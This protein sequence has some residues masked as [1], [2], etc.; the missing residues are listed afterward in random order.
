V[1]KLA[2]LYFIFVTLYWLPAILLNWGS[3]GAYDDPAPLGY[4]LLRVAIPII[5]LVALYLQPRFNYR[6]MLYFAFFN[7]AILTSLFDISTVISL[8]IFSSTILFIE[9]INFSKINIDKL[10]FLLLPVFYCVGLFE[11]LGLLKSA[12]SYGEELRVVST[13]GGPN[14]SGVIFGCFSVYFATTLKKKFNT[15]SFINFLLCV[16]FLFLSGSLSAIISFS[17]VLAF[18]FPKII[19]FAPVVLIPILFINDFFLLKINYLVYAVSGAGETTGSFSDRLENF[20]YILATISS[21]PVNFL[22]GMDT[23]SESD[24]FGTLGRF[25]VIGL[26]LLL[27]TISTLPKNRY[28]YL[29]LLQSLITP[30]LFSFPSFQVIIFFAFLHAQKYSRLCSTCRNSH[31]MQHTSTSLERI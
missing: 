11:V 27:T 16:A 30:F 10:L 8:V 4:K 23:T 14:N 2:A 24:F 7:W 15:F 25:G 28:L 18:I 1:K 12:H 26:I 20:S 13:F 9:R 19:F 5:A 3:Y 22:F 17:V 21:D 29:G 31:V 6:D